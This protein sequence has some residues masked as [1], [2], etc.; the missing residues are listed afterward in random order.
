MKKQPFY[1]NVVCVKA[2]GGKR[3]LWHAYERVGNMI[4]S[5]IIGAGNTAD[6]AIRDLAVQLKAVAANGN[7]RLHA[8]SEQT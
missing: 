5:G 3:S 6:N 4:D 1:R 7:W 8:P 2:Q